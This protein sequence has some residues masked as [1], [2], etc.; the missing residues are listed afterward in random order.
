MGKDK[1]SSSKEEQPSGEDKEKSGEVSSLAP[2]AVIKLADKSMQQQTVLL[3]SALSAKQLD[4]YE[5]FRRST[6][7][8]AAVKR[9]MQS[10]S[11]T[12]VPQNAVIAMAGIT[13]VYVGEIVELACQARENLHETGPLQPKHIREAVRIMR[14]NNN[15]PCTKYK[16]VAAIFK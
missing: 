6:M 11:S 5:I 14:R 8:R 10:V 16:K 4:Q 7:P 9:L 15:M 3:V 12:N 2:E 13:K 1:K